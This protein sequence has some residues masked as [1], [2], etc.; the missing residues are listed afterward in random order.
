MDLNY[1]SPTLR[2]PLK[3]EKSKQFFFGFS[4][5]S[6]YL[7]AEIPLTGFVSGQQVPVSINVNNE[8][9]VDVSEI[10]VELVKII[11]Y[12]SES[13]RM[14]TRERIEYS[15]V[16]QCAGVPVKSKA[17]TNTSLV[18][19]PIPPTNVGTCRVLSIFYEVHVVA[20]VGAFHR[21]AILRLPIMIGTVP[22]FA[23]RTISY[24]QPQPYQQPQSI[25]Q[26]QPY[27][28]TVP[29]LPPAWTVPTTSAGPSSYQNLPLAPS[30][31][32]HNPS[33]QQDMPPPSYQ[34]AMAV[35]CADG[36]TDEGL[37]D[38]M[39]FNP[40]YPVFNFANYGIQPP[41]AQPTNQGINQEP[42]F[43][44]PPPPPAYSTN[45]PHMQPTLLVNAPQ[46]YSNDEKRKY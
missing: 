12:N 41:H 7:T 24:Q 11:H 23:S 30:A 16:T 25:Q 2:N 4:S 27:Q 21:N 33:E 6:L 17:A 28:S 40:R 26:T 8:S 15:A 36:D 31:P 18:I 14:K 29:N 3:V 39:L 13:P 10:S 32:N 44:Q 35:T 9:T 1:E 45:N 42:I 46:F 19:P 34:E 43:N 20:K 22:L 5:K 37:D 38:Q